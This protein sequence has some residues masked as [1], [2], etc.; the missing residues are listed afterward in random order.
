LGFEA[1]S[2]Q[3]SE[4]LVSSMG[5]EAL[6]MLRPTADPDVRS[7][8]LAFTDALQALLLRGELPPMQ[9]FIDVRPSLEQAYPQ[10]AMLRPISLDEIRRVCQASRRIRSFFSKEKDS[11]LSKS[12]HPIVILKELETQIECT[13]DANGRILESAS[14][15]LRH[16]RRKLHQ[17]QEALREKIRGLLNHAIQQ[18]YAA[19]HQLTIRAGRMVIPLR[20]DAKRKMRGFIHDSS[21]TGQTVYL[22][23]ATCLDLGNEV[24]ILEGQEQREIERILRELTTQVR[25]QVNAIELNLKILGEI[26]LLH[27]KAQLSVRLGGIVPKL[28]DKPV[29]D[30]RD[31]KNSALFLASLSKTVIPLTISLGGETC[32]LVITGPNAGG[33]TVAM[34]TCGLMLVML[35]CGIPVQA[36][37][38]SIFGTF[39]QILVEIGDEQSIEH[40]L[41]TFSARVSGLGKMCDVAAEGVLLLIDEIGTGTDPAE[42]AAL[43]QAVLEHF[44]DSGALTIVTTHHGTL[45]AYAHENKG[46]VNGSMDFDEQTLQPTF[47]FRQGLPGSSYAFRIASRMKFNPIVLA[48]ARQILGKPGVTLES[49]IVSY[50]ERIYKLE[51]AQAPTESESEPKD[52]K[53]VDSATRTVH[54]KQGKAPPPPP[55]KI[56]IGQQAVIDGGNTPC[57]IISIEGRY[58]LVSAGNIR[59][60][61][62]LDRLKPVEGKKI[63]RKGTAKISM[64]HVRIDVRGFR[65]REAL[66][67]VEK[68]LDQGT[69][70]N[71]TTVEIVHGT[72][73]GALRKA[74]HQYLKTDEVNKAFECSDINPGVTIV[75]I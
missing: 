41:S 43:A 1:V 20:S 7:E 30:I 62:A 58:A 46:V 21:A 23:P 10:Q 17:R 15:E 26:D 8:S 40:D 14:S 64:P 25:E 61:V 29:L 53:R 19:E 42:G 49:L 22:E 68:L 72:G 45:K 4:I 66:S 71:L 31:G 60:K 34:K 51:S 13:V 65:V 52:E 28:S 33:K 6:N 69:G 18:G 2:R 37:P 44:T 48:R 56:D 54:R 35:G 9:D 12:V 73:T 67:E 27:A 74:I 50:R 39:R 70:A 5:M 38:E 47:L 57:E 3:L 75:K 36:H 11:L 59:M 32:T 24:R 55:A 63:S 16:I